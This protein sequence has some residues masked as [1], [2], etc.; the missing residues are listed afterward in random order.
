M[1]LSLCLAKHGF[2]I[3]FVN[4]EINHKMIMNEWKQ[5]DN[6]GDRLRLV[7]IPDGL[8]FNEDRKNPD[9]FS[10]AIWGIMA[11]KLEEL[12]EETNGADDE[13]ITCVVVDQG[14]G[15]TLEIA[16]KMRIHQAFFYPMVVTKM[17]LLL[18]IPKLI[19]D[20]IISNEVI[21]VAFGSLTIFNKQQFQELAIGLELS[22]RRCLWIV[23]SYSTDSRNDVYPK[24][25]LDRVGTR[26]K[27]VRWAPQQ[28]I[29]FGDPNGRLSVRE[30][31]LRFD[32]FSQE[33]IKPVCAF[34]VFIP[35]L[36]D[37]SVRA[38]ALNLKAV[39]LNIVREGGSSSK[40]FQHFMEWLKA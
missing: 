4:I 34:F 36:G 27:I 18:S 20:G 30:Q 8:E 38:R 28:K 33:G 13:K 25:F 29:E 17:A 37:K 3:T 24:G 9:K 35:S 6:I 39:A 15:S 23:Q 26:G 31:S 14:M 11:R 32:A 40:N 21:Y 16:A 2:R 5:E 19:N 7:W 10:E 22:N 12:I 1:E